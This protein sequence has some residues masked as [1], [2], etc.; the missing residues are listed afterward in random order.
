MAE[1]GRFYGL[2]VVRAVPDHA[3]ALMDCAVRERWP[4]L[5]LA[6]E[7]SDMVP[8]VCLEM[9]RAFVSRGGT[10]LLNGVVPG[11]SKSLAAISNALGLTLPVGLALNGNPS[12]VV[13]TAQDQSFAGEL[14][15]LA[16]PCTRSE[17]ALSESSDAVTLVS[18]RSGSYLFPAVAEFVVGSG[19]VVVSAGTQVVRREPYAPMDG[20]QILPAL[21]LARQVYGQAAWRAPMAFANFVIDDPALRNGTLGLD[22]R[23]ALGVARTHDF[24]ITVATIPRELAVAEPEVVDLLRRSGRW[25]SACYHGNDHSGYEFFLPDA[26]RYRH[27]ARPLS[28]QQSALSQAV[29]R[30]ESFAART[31]LALDRVMVFPHG[32]GPAQIFSTLQSLGFLAACN[33]DDRFPLAAAVPTDFDLGLRPADVAWGGFPLIWRR[34]LPDQM[35]RL[36]LFLGRPAITFGHTKALGP[37]FEPFVQRAQEIHRIKGDQ[38][39]W[40]SLEDISRHSYLQR[41]DPKLGW[42]V[43]MLSN[44]ICLHNAEAV[45]LT[46]HVERANCPDG[47][48]LQSD[49]A[50]QFA[51][52]TLTITIPAGGARTV[53][54]ASPDSRSLSGGRPCSLEHFTAERSSA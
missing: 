15:G 20:L 12:E 26:K 24:H 11:S 16:I 33:Y 25:L 4:L 53:R 46:Y 42:R 28:G 17:T 13:V 2:E 27:R 37:D 49:A 8:D 48:A 3:V 32:V 7:G 40:S 34:G 21:M 5:A 31:G 36:D 22:Y 39:H 30:G 45:P 51:A 19:R 18:V 23:H 1:V 10:L 38:V 52:G 47:Y 29:S 44:E 43:L 54:L 14:A 50:H 35:F 41:R 6:L 9:L